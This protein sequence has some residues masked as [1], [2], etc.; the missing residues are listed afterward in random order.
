MEFHYQRKYAIT[1][2]HHFRYLQIKKK[3]HL[4]SRKHWYSKVPAFFVDVDAIDTP[5]VNKDIV[6][7]IKTFQ[8]RPYREHFLDID[9]I[10]AIYLSTREENIFLSPVHLL[11]FVP[12][13]PGRLAIPVVIDSVLVKVPVNIQTV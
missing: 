9:C 13:L 8:V 6:S 11:I 7:L 1:Y 10:S 12:L 4:D 2:S 3:I 5:Y